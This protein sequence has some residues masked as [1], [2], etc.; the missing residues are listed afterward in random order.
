MIPAPFEYAAPQTLGEAIR[1]LSSEGEEAKLLA[2]GHS[3]LPMMKLRLANPKILIDLRR[4]S[5]L[6]GIRREGDQIVIGALTT[7]YE[8]ES[9]ALLKEVCPL[10]PETARAIGDVQVRNRGTIGGS[11]AHAD[12][13]A[14]LPAAIL[15]LGGE[16]RL[17]GSDDQRWV[18]GED[19]FLGLMTTA[20][21]PTQIITEIRV[22]V[23]AGAVGT[24][25]L[26]IAQKASG[27]AIVGVAVWVKVED[28][29]CTDIGVAVTGLGAKPFRA[30]EVE[31]KLWGKRVDH[32]FLDA[33]ASH[34][35]R[36]IDPLDDIHASARFRA[37]LARVLTD[38]AIHEA[39]S[40]ATSRKS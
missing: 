28:K 34:V 14:D 32:T 29:A 24:A 25:Y 12:P 22:P 16:L 20:L 17:T 2:G 8:I 9:S 33:D 13:A 30:K 23:L 21:K 19:F 3:L 15:A 39:I 11:L 36:G 40:K 1:L 38:R 7:H 27:F 10:L 35:D 37:H 26:K 31:K 6:S 5:G 18:K 4:I